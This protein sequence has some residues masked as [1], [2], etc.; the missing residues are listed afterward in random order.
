MPAAVRSKTLLAVSLVGTLALVLSATALAG[1]G[2]FAP[3]PGESPNSDNINASYNYIAIF[4]GAILVL[5]EGLLIAFVV[6]FRRKGRARDAEGARIHG[7]TQLEIAWTVAPVLI[8]VAIGTFVF[9]KLPA[10]SDVPPATAAGGRLEVKVSGHQFYWEFEYPNGVVAVDRLRAPVGQTVRLEVTSP[11][12]DVIHSWW[13]PALG[14]KIDAIPGRVNETWF[15]AGRAGVFTGQCAEFCGVQ[16]AVMTATVEAMPRE[17][18]E[19]WLA[20]EKDAQQAGTSAL[21]EQ[22]FAGACAKC[23]GLAGEGLIGPALKGSSLVSD[24]KG[25]E[26]LVREGRGRMPAVGKDWGDTQMKA[27][28]S[29][30]KENLGNQG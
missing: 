22:T 15:R 26:T 2:G 6:R 29:Y 12:H 30:L 25:I 18:F 16:H 20:G 9:W 19:A 17:E 21:G 5:V 10:I 3:V 8:L 11:D 13:I 7:N 4:T 1:N 23:H 14:G 28:T 27:L 24:E